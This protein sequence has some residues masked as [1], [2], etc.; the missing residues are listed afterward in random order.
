MIEEYKDLQQSAYPGEYQNENEFRSMQSNMTIKLES[1]RE[2]PIDQIVEL[3]KNGFRIE[4]A[5]Q[6][7]T[8]LAADGISISSGA[9]VLIGLGVLA[10]MYIRKHPE[11]F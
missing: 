5:S 9:I 2:M 11:K 3:Y 8:I 4:D 1:M 10:Y 7:P 6:P